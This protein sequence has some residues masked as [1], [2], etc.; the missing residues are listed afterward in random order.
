MTRCSAIV[1]SFPARI[2]A[3][4]SSTPG[5][6]YHVGRSG[7]WLTDNAISFSKRACSARALAVDACEGDAPELWMVLGTR[8]ATTDMADFYAAFKE[9]MRRVRKV[10][11]GAEYAS[12]LEFTTGY[13][14]R[15]GGRRRPHWNVLVKGVPAAARRRFRKIAVP[16]W[17]DN[18]DAAPGAQFVRSGLGSLAVL[19]HTAGGRRR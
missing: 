13:G 11:P 9:V 8:T 15:S 3:P 16:A 4:R 2:T 12:L 17:C 19:V 14:P 7:R 6:S 5:C 18:V 10:W 1:D